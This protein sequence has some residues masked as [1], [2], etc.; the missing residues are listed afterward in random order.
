MVQDMRGPDVGVPGRCLRTTLRH[1]WRC[2]C[3]SLGLSMAE[4]VC[5]GLLHRGYL[6]IRSRRHINTFARAFPL[7]LLL[8]PRRGDRG[9]RG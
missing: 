4:Y 1:L 9:W 7:V 5:V 3:G 2:A 8:G 6:K